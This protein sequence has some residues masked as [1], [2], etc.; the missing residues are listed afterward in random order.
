MCM[1]T[2]FPK[3]KKNSIRID[4]IL[5]NLG[6][7]KLHF[8]YTQTWKFTFGWIIIFGEFMGF[9]L[10]K[11]HFSHRAKNCQRY[12]QTA[13][14]WQRKTPSILWEDF[15]SSASFH[16]TPPQ[17][18]TFKDSTT[19]IKQKKSS[20]KNKKSKKSNQ[21]KTKQPQPPPKKKSPFF[22]ISSPRHVAGPYHW[23]WKHESSTWRAVHRLP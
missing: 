7:K 6:F 10:P 22:L 3:T 15:K 16:S 12:D 8:G 21:A 4:S 23:S 17:K 14:S 5:F 20:N 9:K 11:K 2:S 18:K 1:D 13:G 19:Q